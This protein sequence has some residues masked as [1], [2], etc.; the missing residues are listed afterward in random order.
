M[1]NHP[2]SFLG[3]AVPTLDGS[4]VVV[5]RLVKTGEGYRHE[6]HILRPDK[7]RHILSQHGTSPKDA[8]VKTRAALSEH[9]SVPLPDGI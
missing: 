6:L 3:L 7:T 8:M 5:N 9:Y 1:S 4:R 2:F